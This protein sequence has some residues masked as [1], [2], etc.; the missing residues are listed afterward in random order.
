M[1]R[2]ETA[3][4]TIHSYCKHIHPTRTADVGLPIENIHKCLSKFS[5]KKT[6]A[7]I[8]IAYRNVT[9]NSTGIQFQ[10]LAVEEDIVVFTYS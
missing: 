7:C 3:V 8:K 6:I 5:S 2:P 4:I 9:I 10:S 1:L